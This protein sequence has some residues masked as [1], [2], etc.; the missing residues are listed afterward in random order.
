[1]R[2]YQWNGHRFEIGARHLTDVQMAGRVRM[3]MRDQLDH[4][5]VCT[6]ARDRIMCLTEEKSRLREALA[7]IERLYYVEG[8]DALWR[9]AQMRAIATK[10]LEAIE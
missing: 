5:S 9:S 6:D 4:E 1:M 7:E 3:L 2:T 10:T 8:T